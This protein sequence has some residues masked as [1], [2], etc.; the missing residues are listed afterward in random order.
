MPPKDNDLIKKGRE[1]LNTSEP[2][3]WNDFLWRALLYIEHK[4][5]VVWYCENKE[6]KIPEDCKPYSK[7]QIS[8]SIVY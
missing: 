4:E 3:F 8:Q 2:A 7:P 5:C 6:P 1:T